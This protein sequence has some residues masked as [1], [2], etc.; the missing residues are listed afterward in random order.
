MVSPC[1]RDKTQRVE[2]DNIEGLMGEAREYLCIKVANQS[3]LF[4]DGVVSTMK[5]LDMVCT[6]TS[7]ILSMAIYRII[8]FLILSTY[9]GRKKAI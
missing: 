3:P 4:E 9:K 7:S 5:L 8:V 2:G 1:S 6:P